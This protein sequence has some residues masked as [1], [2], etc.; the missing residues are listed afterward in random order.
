ML[1]ATRQSKRSARTA[2]IPRLL[3]VFVR[4]EL[5]LHRGNHRAVV[6]EAAGRFGPRFHANGMALEVLRLDQREQITARLADVEAHPRD[7][8]LVP[9]TRVGDNAVPVGHD[10]PGSLWG[11][12]LADALAVVPPGHQG[13]EVELLRL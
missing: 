10:R 4:D 7:T 5:A 12:A 9:V 8:R 11:A 3:S 6:Q 13:G 1:R 2:A